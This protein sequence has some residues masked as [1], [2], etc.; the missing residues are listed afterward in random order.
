MQYI[1]LTG[2]PN[3]LALDNFHNNCIISTGL[4]EEQ[5]CSIDRRKKSASKVTAVDLVA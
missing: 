4:R 3:Y 2:I 1:P 5:D